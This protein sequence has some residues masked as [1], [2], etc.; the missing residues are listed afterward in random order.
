MSDAREN[1]HSTLRDAVFFDA[2]KREAFWTY[3]KEDDSTN[4]GRYGPSDGYK[5][6]DWDKPAISQYWLKGRGW[7]KSHSCRMGILAA[8]WVL[9]SKVDRSIR[10]SDR[11]FCGVY[12]VG[13][14]CGKWASFGL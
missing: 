14:T 8:P 3:P 10:G 13:L 5:G 1:F 9:R 2:W 12:V 6:K 7:T 11:T 4:H